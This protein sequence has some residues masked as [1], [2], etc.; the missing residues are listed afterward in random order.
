MLP[1]FQWVFGCFLFIFII[2]SLAIAFKRPKKTKSILIAFF[3]L[4]G[5]SLLF[6]LIF[7]WGS[8]YQ[9]KPQFIE[10]GAYY[11]LTSHDQNN[12]TF[13][14]GDND[15]VDYVLDGN[16]R[17][18]S[19]F[20]G[21]V[22]F[23]Y[24]QQSGQGDAS[25]NNKI[26]WTVSEDLT[27][28]LE[29]FDSRGYR[30]TD[31]AQGLPL[32]GET[33]QIVIKWSSEKKSLSLTC[34][35]EL[36]PS[37]HARPRVIISHP[38][39]AIKAF[40]LPDKESASEG[41]ASQNSKIYLTSSKQAV[42]LQSADASFIPVIQ[43]S[44]NSNNV[45]D[46]NAFL[47]WPA[48]DDNCG[49]YIVNNGVARLCFSYG[50]RSFVGTDRG[51]VFTIISI[52]RT[53]RL[54]WSLICIAIWCVTGIFYW[55]FIVSRI[56]DA[57][58][59]TDPD[60]DSLFLTADILLV[61]LP[62]LQMLLAVRFVLCL[63][64]YWW[65]P[66][67]TDAIESALFS[68]LFIPLLIFI[69]CYA[70]GLGILGNLF[71]GTIWSVLGK[72][73]KDFRTYLWSEFPPLIFS[74][75]AIVT[76]G[77]S[78]ILLHYT[79]PSHLSASNLAFQ[80]WGYFWQSIAI[81]ALVPF[82]ICFLGILLGFISFRYHDNS[83]EVDPFTYFLINVPR[84]R[85]KGLAGK[86]PNRLHS[87]SIVAI[88]LLL[89]GGF[90]AGIY[91]FAL[92][93]SYL[94][95]NQL[96]QMVCA[97]LASGTAFVF[98]FLSNWTARYTAGD[99][100]SS[101]FWTSFWHNFFIIFLCLAVIFIFR[102]FLTPYSEKGHINPAVLFSG[103]RLRTNTFFEILIFILNI[104]LLKNFFESWSQTNENFGWSGILK[105]LVLFLAPVFMFVAS[106]LASRDFGASLVHIPAQIGLL[107][108]VT[109]SWA[110]W[111][112]AAGRRAALV[113]FTAPFLIVA[114]YYL[115]IATQAASFLTPD[116]STFWQ[117]VLLRQGVD[118]ALQ[119]S[120]KGGDKLIEAIEQ[121]WRMMNYA[122]AGGVTGNGFGESPVQKGGKT[123]QNITL[124]ELVFS[125]YVLSEHGVLGGLAVLGLYSLILILVFLGAWR[126]YNESTVER[127]RELRFGI[128]GGL[129]LMLF[130]PSVYMIAANVNE[131]ILTGQNLTLLNLRSESELLR[132][133][134]IL[135]L[136]VIVLQ[137]F[138][139]R[140]KADLSPDSPSLVHLGGL[141]W[142]LLKGRSRKSS[143]L[144][145]LGYDDDSPATTGNAVIFTN[146]FL[147]SL[148][149]LALVCFS[150]YG[151]IQ[152]SNNPEYVKNLDYK[153]LKLKAAE[154]I[155]N[156]NVWFEPI[157]TESSAR[158]GCD[159]KN[160]NKKA[161]DDPGLLIPYNLCIDDNVSGG[162][163]NETLSAFVNKWNNAAK[164][165][166]ASHATEWN[167]ENQFFK[168][169]KGSAT[170]DTAPKILVNQ[171]SY[172]QVSPFLARSGWNGSLTEAEVQ[173]NIDGV[174]IGTNFTLSL[175]RAPYAPGKKSQMETSTDKENVYSGTGNKRVYLDD[176]NSLSPGRGFAICENHE[177]NQPI[178]MISTVQGAKGALLD[179]VSGDFNLFING[180][181]LLA[182]GEKGTV[183]RTRID[184][185]DV[186]AYAKKDRT[187][188]NIPVHVFVYSR[189]KMGTFSFV[190]WI[191]GERKRFYPQGESLAIAKQITSAIQS[192]R[193]KKTENL[194][195]DDISLTLNSSLNHDV[196]DLL[197][198]W[199]ACM[200][201]KGKAGV[202]K[203]MKVIKAPIEQG[204]SR[205]MAV[206][207]MDPNTGSMLALASDDGKPYDPNRIPDP[208]DNPSDKQNLNLV[209][210]DIGSAIKPM[211]ASATLLSF[212]DLY[213][214]KISDHWLDKK[215]LL[216]LP[217]GSK[218]GIRGHKGA[219]EITWDTFLPPS[220]N[221][222]AVTLAMLGMSRE[223][224][225]VPRFG[226]N[227]NYRSL[228]PPYRIELTDNGTSLGLPEWAYP[229]MFDPN[230]QNE[231]NR[232][233]GT[234]VAST[235]LAKNLEILF[236][237]KTA[238]P[239][240]KSFDNAMWW[241]GV[242]DDPKIFAESNSF[243]NVSPEITN[244][245]FPK[246]PDFAALR[247]VLLGGGFSTGDS[248][249]NPY[250][251]IGGK[252]SN[253]FLTQAIARIVTG[254]KVR[255]QIVAGVKNTESVD[256]PVA[257][258]FSG[259][260][261]SVWR[262]TLL[263]SLE[264]VSTNGTA[265]GA[266]SPI[267][268][269]IKKDATDFTIFSKTGTL[270]NPQD[271]SLEDTSNFIFTAGLW[272]E[273]E[274][275]IEKAVSGAIY[276]EQGKL[277]QA[278]FFAAEL[279]KLLNN[280]HYLWGKP[281][282]K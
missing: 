129:A 175:I 219:L 144:R 70:F 54:I 225:G 109:S 111:K 14:I 155:K 232:I 18:E 256:P 15:Q 233:A 119:E 10:S 169:D 224:A 192:N 138:S 136:L 166:N 37:D 234:L 270:E 72:K 94:R 228:Q 32:K 241:S 76:F 264:A 83:G 158:G 95:Q 271:E 197:R 265:A 44:G 266:L 246:I 110:I 239:E 40:L 195:D 2:F 107:V 84:R 17:G 108:L 121:Q 269:S 30:F 272:N 96:S 164:G 179:S 45:G 206:S 173:N 47:E 280:K 115:L 267:I 60:N 251:N 135:M 125:V 273:K 253:V 279:I 25:Y 113:A 263:H 97:F 151:I 90:S 35:L 259:A 16:C 74:I 137:P 152:A 218:E 91:F 98:W 116:G 51:I 143:K 201:G 182:Q 6:V 209:R 132:S 105:W 131:V 174:L 248:S 20:K 89:A 8:S 149:L 128:V 238:E 38:Q 11:P 64:A 104:R 39:A 69:G 216:A 207:L 163:K 28:K 178:F 120:E 204:S 156:N 281:I 42:G 157:S 202:C 244:F 117:R 50:A 48:P 82:S 142:S 33:E 9:L 277:G 180:T 68:L 49:N 75:C 226:E 278:Q 229:N 231:E 255:A 247:S 88:A 258:W 122:A 106:F 187:G 43:V 185:G 36:T 126:A 77:A 282:E 165:A 24:V 58:K 243:D 57:S 62:A 130:F 7:L 26:I 177:C 236:D 215:K 148:F 1:N 34:D 13:S 249:L 168:L 203:D 211:T 275:R 79:S 227:G 123:F 242:V 191:N 162:G 190:T 274:K 61:F 184:D 181:A 276:I 80:N 250:G 31:G 3:S 170:A 140:K 154:Y 217:L 198:R 56:Q 183:G 41:E 194:P 93:N 67:S 63:R 210:H 141:F 193:E 23:T 196:Y 240:V 81:L 167:D 257:E 27:G 5:A 92:D 150:I 161:P 112:Y 160:K 21:R 245:A 200:D 146:M 159:G 186:I 65:P 205:R 252:W 29:I 114:I 254:N 124:D 19:C 172:N 147:V 101:D 73:G 12:S 100:D 66:L 86:R 199:R 55:R 22:D 208:A 153:P 53:Q 87:L 46:V 59:E 260:R 220:D 71:P 221:L 213:N 134:V 85:N 214:M 99:E 268:I 212:P 78:F 235:P 189:A 139:L 133:G 145:E 230:G 127:G 176:P 222:Y 103:A 171:S 237:I 223:N 118:A 52:D 261:V 188:T 4:Y 102:I 262:A